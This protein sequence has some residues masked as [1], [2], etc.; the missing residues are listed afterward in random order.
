M[1][2]WIFGKKIR[3]EIKSH[4]DD[5]QLH[6]SHSFLNIKNDIANIHSH[7]S[8]KDKRILE[9]EEKIKS[10]EHKFFYTFQPKEEEPKQ[11]ESVEKEVNIEIPE[12]LSISDMASLTYTQQAILKALYE[13][14]IQ[15]DGPI[16]FK[17]LA[18]YLYPGKKYSAVRTTLSEYIDFLSTYGFAKKDKVGRETVANITKKGQKLAKELVKKRK[19]KIN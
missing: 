12:D 11:I 19:Q 1:I 6:L 8:H 17:S 4:F 9:L 13:L 14:Q 3:D 2:S 7:L 5:F 10:L 18:Q 15:L 16:S